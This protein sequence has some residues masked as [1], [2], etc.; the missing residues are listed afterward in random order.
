MKFGKICPTCKRK[1]FVFYKCLIKIRKFCSLKCKRLTPEARRKV[2]LSQIGRIPWNKG[3]KNPQQSVRQMGKKNP[4]YGK[5]GKA[6]PS[7]KGG[8]QKMNGYIL[9]YKP[10]HRYNVKKYVF[11]HRL[12]MEKKLG[13]YLKPEEIVHH[14]NGKKDDNSFKNLELLSQADHARF[15]GYKHNNLNKYNNL[16]NKKLEY[17]FQK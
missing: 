5:R 11:E 9:I 13:R 1:F 2:S 12:V 14:I 4:M 10:E 3:L 7:W 17:A 8:K 15:H 6:S 16:K